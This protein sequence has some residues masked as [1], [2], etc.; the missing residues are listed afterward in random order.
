VVAG[1]KANGTSLTFTPAATYTGTIGISAKSI[2]PI[3]LFSETGKDSTGAVSTQF[4]RDT[5]ASAHNDFGNNSGA[6]CTTCS[7]N[8]NSGYEGQY[9]LTTGSYNTNSG[10]GGQYNLTTGSGNANSGFGG[11]YNLTTG[12]GNA[13][14]GFEG[15]SSLTTG[16]YNT[17][18]GY[19]GQY[20]LT[21]GSGNTSSGYYAGRYIANGSTPNQTSSNSL[22]DGYETYA[23]ADGDTNENVVGNGVIGA[24]SNTTVLG[25]A[26][27]TDT[28]F[29]GAGAASIAHAAEYVATT[30]ALGATTSTISLL[31]N[32]TAST[33]GATVQ[34]SPADEKDGHAWNTSGTPADNFVRSR[35]YLQPVSG[36]TP[37][38]TWHWQASV[39]TGTAS[40]SDAMTLTSAGTLAIAALNNTG[41]SFT[42]NGHTCTIVSTV[43]TCP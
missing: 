1:L 25:N 38:G 29:G 42:F 15:Q 23:K 41:A 12:S 28:Y 26:S 7:N 22:Y 36:A 3:T 8:A 33:S 14:S 32:T 18:S 40:W 16:S 19:A 34:V 39:D 6:Y 10:F 2:S 20:N 35:T 31:G 30:T 27:I 13:N 24:G 17:N 5:L 21:T 9:S 11:Q 37:T 43:V 4:L